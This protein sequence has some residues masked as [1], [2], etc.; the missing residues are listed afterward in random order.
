MVCSREPRARRPLSWTT[1][2]RAGAAVVAI[3]GGIPGALATIALFA[4]WTARS[5][6][7]LSTGE[8]ELKADK[9]Q[10]RSWE[11]GTLVCRPSSTLNGR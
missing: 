4:H 9:A 5:L 10:H 6:E 1:R 8:P 7:P 2:L 11:D 3:I